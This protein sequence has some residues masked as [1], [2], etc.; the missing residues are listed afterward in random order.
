MYRP[1]RGFS[2]AVVRNLIVLGALLGVGFLVYDTY[3]DGSETSVTP[4]PTFAPIGAS[5]SAP[6]ITPMQPATTAPT[7]ATSTT[8]S[9][10]LGLQPG[11]DA[12]IFIP[13]V[14]VSAP[15]I[16][17]IIRDGTWDVS[18][19]GT[20]VGYLQ[21][22]SWLGD[23]GNIVLSGHVEMSDGRTGVFASLDEIAVGD[24]VLLTENGA[25][26]QYQVQD[27]KYVDP[28]DLSVVSQTSD[29]TLTLITCS[30]YNFLQNTYDT[31]LVVV[32]KRMAA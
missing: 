13:S 29:E 28:T 23:L 16:T 19:L 10:A 3:F 11:S 24:V 8:T 15:V 1:R 22:T 9:S 5:T 14:G 26:Y 20:N 32:A 21:G 7:P 31:R 30:D 25:N 27:I 12:E 6:V 4:P 2:G 18:Q 17:S